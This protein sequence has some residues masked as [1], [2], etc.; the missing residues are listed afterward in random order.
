V[1]DARVASEFFLAFFFNFLKFNC[2]EHLKDD[3]SGRSRGYAFVNME[4]SDAGY[5]AMKGITGMSID[6]RDIRVEVC[7]GDSKR[8][9]RGG[10]GGRRDDRRGGGGGDRYGGE[11]SGGGGRDRYDD[12]RPRDRYVSILNLFGLL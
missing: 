8:G 12:R 7:S 4:D 5:R 2:C 11:R 10:G 6:G 3:S 1:K 9:E